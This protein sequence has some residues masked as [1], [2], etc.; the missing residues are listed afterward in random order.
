VK[1]NLGKIELNG[2]GETVNLIKAT[3]TSIGAG[4]ES[5]PIRIAMKIATNARRIPIGSLRLDIGAQ[6]GSPFSDNM[7]YKRDFS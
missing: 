4:R 7:Q 6:K 3:R 1:L 2:D 5:I